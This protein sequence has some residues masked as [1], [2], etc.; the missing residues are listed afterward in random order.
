M[1]EKRQRPGDWSVFL[2]IG[3]LK[4]NA[5]EA[6]DQLDLDEVERSADP[7]K[8]VLELLDKLYQYEDA[9]ETPSP[10]EGFG[11]Q[12]DEEMQAYLIRH[13]TMMQK[14]RERSK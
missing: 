1:F 10:C 13:Q 14:M 5:W 11:R 12:N 4:D 9:V 6:T 7:F 3:L 2:V 8:P